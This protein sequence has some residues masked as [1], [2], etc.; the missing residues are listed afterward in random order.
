MADRRCEQPRLFGPDAVGGV[1][2]RLAVDDADRERLVA[3]RR[4]ADDERRVRR[5]NALLLDEDAVEELVGP[6]EDARDRAEVLHEP[7]IAARERP[8]ADAS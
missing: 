2:C 4:L 8:V 7:G 1:V 6:V 5:L 3:E